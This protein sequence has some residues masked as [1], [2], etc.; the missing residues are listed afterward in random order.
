MGFPHY[1]DEYKVM[2][3]APYGEPKYIDKLN[4]VIQLTKDGLFKLNLKY[5]RSGTQGVI[6]YGDDNIP[7]VESMYSDLMVKD[8]NRVALSRWLFDPATGKN[9]YLFQN[10]F[11]QGGLP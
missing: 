10:S 2:G 11:Y 3:M 5:F 8:G 9:E 4:D 1:G 7:I 6:S